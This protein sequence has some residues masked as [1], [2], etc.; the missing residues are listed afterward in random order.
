MSEDK[1]LEEKLW[2]NTDFYSN[3]SD[4]SKGL[5]FE[6]GNRLAYTKKDFTT[7][8]NISGSFTTQLDPAVSGINYWSVLVEL[9]V[10]VLL[11]DLL[12]P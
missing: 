4:N 12:T 7:F 2:F 8:L 1:S 9:G 11:P 5:A 6:V 10:S 3:G